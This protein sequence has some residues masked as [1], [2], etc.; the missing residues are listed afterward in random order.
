MQPR[1]WSCS[2]G[3]R[4]VLLTAIQNVQGDRG[5]GHK[6]SCFCHVEFQIMT[7]HAHP[8][9]LG[10]M[11]GAIALGGKL[12]GSGQRDAWLP[13]CWRAAHHR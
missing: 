7:G 4:T 2:T 5:L 12:G 10:R 3:Q 13:Q 11:D 8:L 9:P 6:E 1:I